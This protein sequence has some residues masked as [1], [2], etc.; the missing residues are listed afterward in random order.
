MGKIEAGIWKSASGK[1]RAHTKGR[2]LDDVAWAEVKDLLKGKSRDRDLLIEHLHLIQDKFR[3]VSTAHMRA[4]AEE[5]GMSSAEVYEVASFYA[6]FDIMRDGE[7]PPPKLTIRVCDSLSCMMAGAGTLKKKLED[8]LNPAE[9]RVLRAPCMGRCNAAPALELGHAHIEEATFEKVTEAIENKMVHPTIP[10]FQ[11][12][13]DY[14]SS[15]GY[16]TL[17]RLRKSGD[18]KEVQTE[19]LN[20]GLR[21]LGGAGFPSGK[22]WEFVR[23][24]E[25]PRYLAVNGD[26]GEPGTFKDR[27]YLERTPHLFLEGMLIAAW[28]VEA[29]KAFIYM[30]DEYPSCLLYT[31]PSPRDIS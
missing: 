27:Y 28:A 20:A 18:W 4:L 25:G 5:M 15:G 16:D 2:P 26:E 11:N 29:E 3:C 6:H 9:V 23:A 17:K 8:G 21:G 31:S 12:F 7:Q 24:N 13:S 14:V 30:R 1:G 10:E 22:K 19:I